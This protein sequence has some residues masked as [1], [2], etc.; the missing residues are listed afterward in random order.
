MVIVVSHG[1]TCRLGAACAPR[2]DMT[3][4]EFAEW[5]HMHKA[6]KDAR[7][8]YL[9]DWHFANEF[10]HYKAYNTPEYFQ[11]DWLNDFYD[12]K[13][14]L[15]QTRRRKPTVTAQPALGIHLS[16]VSAVDVAASQPRHGECTG[17]FAND[18]PSCCSCC[19]LMSCQMQYSASG[20]NCCPGL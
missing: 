4:G 19:L 9:K 18:S 12:M 1:G 3:I 8:L 2:L 17:T 14:T 11:E 16:C 10:P 5:W 15:K 13:Q 20:A 7:L 6:G